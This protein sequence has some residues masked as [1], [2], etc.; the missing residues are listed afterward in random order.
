MAY[1]TTTEHHKLYPYTS[2]MASPYSCDPTGATDIAAAIESIKSNQSNVGT[3]YIPHGTFKVA[4]NLTIPAT[5][6]VIRESGARLSIA[7]GVTL[8][9][10][11]GAPI[12]ADGEQL[13]I[14]NGTGT[15]DAIN[16]KSMFWS[17][18]LWGTN[19]AAATAAIASLPVGAKATFKNLTFT[20]GIILN[21]PVKLVGF[22]VMGTTDAPT[23]SKIDASG[24]SGTAITIT[25]GAYGTLV[26][27]HLEGFWLYGSTESGAS[28]PTIGIDI[29]QDCNRGLIKDVLVTGFTQNQ[30][31]TGTYKGINFT[32]TQST[33]SWKLERC[34]LQGNDIGGYFGDR[35][36]NLMIDKCAFLNNYTWGARFINTN[37][38]S[39]Y[40]TQME[41]N[42]KVAD[43]TGSLSVESSTDM[44][45]DIYGEQNT[46]WPGVSVS[47]GTGS[48]T[49]TARR[50]TIAGST[51]IIGNSQATKGLIVKND[52]ADVTNFGFFANFTTANIS[53]V[54]SATL[55][56]VINFKNWS[57]WNYTANSGLQ[58][59][60]I[61][62]IQ[63]L[64][65]H[66]WFSKWW[67][68]AIPVGWTL[69]TRGTFS[70]STDSGKLGPYCLK[71][72]GDTV[73]GE[74]SV[75]QYIMT[76]NLRLAE[77]ADG[78]SVW[79]YVKF[80]AANATTGRINMDGNSQEITKSDNWTWYRLSKKETG[81]LSTWFIKIQLCLSTET[82]IATDE[83]YVG[84]IG[85]F[86]GWAVPDGPV[87]EMDKRLYGQVD[88]EPQTGATGV[89]DAAAADTET[90]TV[91]GASTDD[92]VELTIPYTLS[93]CN[94]YAR[95]TS[96][97]TVTLTVYNPT[98]GAV[99][100]AS[101]T[102]RVIT[103]PR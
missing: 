4:T 88:W 90:I 8:T 96:A 13:F 87:G 45:I 99:N 46:A 18:E 24:V 100:F 70:Q 2:I 29:Q 76:D 20:A 17:I 73:A 71:V 28:T 3:I 98:V 50:I 86:P 62:S 66:P 52:A 15:V 81:A 16:S 27:H 85:V 49:G 59:T 56:D 37:Q 68:S 54:P 6:S 39:I 84:Y 92:F 40:S 65:A 94:A 41:K 64:L 55:N 82:A 93:G 30:G 26:G 61:Q 31:G 51:R 21:R 35:S 83:L 91:T 43:T 97:N 72:V 44:Y 58:T 12:G 80:P 14:L 95:V 67:T 25:A 9:W 47:I 22:G 60:Y 7:T 89:L 32:A 1:P 38:I 79:A 42:G 57:S 69:S 5:M 75:S 11:C 77:F 33:F 101:G 74:V 34:R 78:F 23:G 19:N 36:Q 10:N 63:N 48:G 102:W 53:V 103:T